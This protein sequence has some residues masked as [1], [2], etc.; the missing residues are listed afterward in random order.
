MQV[1]DLLRNAAVRYPQRACV[2]DGIRVL[3]FAEVDERADRAAAAFRRT[4]LVAGDRV[5]L[6]AENEVEHFELQVAA[7]RAGVVL[8]PLNFHC[9]VA[10]LAYIVRD[11]APGLLIYGPGYRDAAAALAV[12]RAWCL[13][14]G[15]G[16]YETALAAGPRVP[17]ASFADASTVATIMY[18][19]GTT[20]RPRGAV[21]SCGALWARVNMI[22]AEADIRLGDVFVQALPMFHIAAHVAYGFCY[23]AST[24]VL[25][26]G[27]ESV[28]TVEALAANRAT[29]VLLVPTMIN[30]LGL[31]EELFDADLTELRM[32]L[33]GA[34]PI[35]PEV[36]RRAI[37]ALPGCGFLQFFG[38]TETFGA[39]LLRP[40]DHDPDA[41][42]ERLASA[43][44]D[45]L[46]FSTRVVDADGEEVPPGVV[47]EVLSRG[48]A[49]MDGYWNNPVG[50]SA[51]LVDGWMHT[52]DLG[53]RGKDGYLYIT[54]RLK[55]MIVSG[56]ENVYPREVEDM[57]YTHPDVL[58]AAVV[59]LPDERWGERVHAVV[60]ARRPSTLSTDVLVAHCRK[61]LAGYKVPKTVEFL[62]QLPKN[63]TGKVLRRSLWD[64]Q[65]VSREDAV[66]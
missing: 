32:V 42:P 26:K 57:L 25:L 29:H 59:R 22:V 40:G 13:E 5:A 61:G 41:H 38:M 20:G 4:G 54:D 43:G 64:G 36:L 2:T 65:R 47:G 15:E 45:A 58:E 39:S 28:G 55:D 27:F 60:V 49:L 48:P 6:L 3:T 14:P 50:T 34:S 1:P 16:E 56:G 44:T 37:T 31:R 18:S 7:I 24:T 17:S 30:M 33:Y 9:T 51:A 11:C 8:V 23:R 63:A 46:S 35:S 53:Y 21:I 62:D 52:D 12:E 19:S 10:E 66:N